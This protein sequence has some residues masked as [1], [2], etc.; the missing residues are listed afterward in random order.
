MPAPFQSPAHLLAVLNG[1]GKP[2]GNGAG[3]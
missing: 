3:E 2:A 1:H